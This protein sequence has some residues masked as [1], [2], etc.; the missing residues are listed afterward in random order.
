MV[1]SSIVRYSKCNKD[2]KTIKHEC[3]LCLKFFHPGCI[4][5]HKIYDKNNKL[6]PCTSSFRIIPGP[7][8]DNAIDMAAVDGYNEETP[9]NDK[10]NEQANREIN[11]QDEGCFD[12]MVQVQSLPLVQTNNINDTDDISDDSKLSDIALTCNASTTN[13]T[14]RNINETVTKKRKRE[15]GESEESEYNISK[16]ID[17]LINKIDD[18]RTEKCDS[19][20]FKNTVSKILKTELCAIETKINIDMNIM[21]NEISGLTQIM[22]NFMQSFGKDYC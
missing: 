10:N 4:G 5:L 9:H 13:K 20:L 15:N 22:G 19:V 16:K 8:A 2:I 11:L 12:S 17:N 6:I 14:N 7:E 1:V 3:L 21:R 18:I